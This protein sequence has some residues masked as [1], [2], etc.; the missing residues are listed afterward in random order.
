MTGFRPLYD[1]APSPELQSLLSPGGFLAPLVDLQGEDI[2]GHFHD[3]HFRVNDEVHVY[4]GLT[5][6]VTVSRN[7]NGEVRLTAHATYQSQACARGLF[8][9]WR[10]DEPGLGEELLHYLRA[11]KASPSRVVGEGLVQEQWARV[12]APWTPFDREGTLAGPHQMG[13]DFPRVQSAL[14]R[15]TDLARSSGWAAPGGRGTNIDQ[16]AVDP[17]GR[18]VLLELK[19][20]SKR[21]AEVYYAPFQLLQYVWEWHA[22]LEEV[23]EDLQALISARVVAGLSPPGTGPLTGGIRAAVGFGADGRS[24]RVKQRYGAVLEVVNQHLPEGVGPVEAWEFTG[25]GPRLVP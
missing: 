3:V 17:E 6:L 9:L 1:R 18:L 14:S 23:W 7:V 13:M 5:R 19:D 24:P 15:L 10:V 12:N 21:A 4:R 22:V 16:L 8:R 11:V 2:A 25:A 20:A